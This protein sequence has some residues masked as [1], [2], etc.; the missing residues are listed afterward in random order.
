MT[1]TERGNQEPSYE[2]MMVILVFHS[3]AT[4]INKSRNRK[5][6]VSALVDHTIVTA[7]TASSDGYTLISAITRA[8]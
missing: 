3:T 2:T 1:S 4:V 6:N 8:T 7:T 5:S